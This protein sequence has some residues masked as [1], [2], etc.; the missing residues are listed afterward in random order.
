MGDFDK[1][2]ELF[3][4]EDLRAYYEF[5][6]SDPMLEDDSVDLA[7]NAETSQEVVQ[8]MTGLQLFTFMLF[9]LAREQNE[10]FERYLMS[11]S[12]PNINPYTQFWIYS[13]IVKQEA[14]N[15]Q[16]VR[17]LQMSTTSGDP[18]G[19]GEVIFN[20]PIY[21]EV[22]VQVLNEIRI[23]ITSETALPIPFAEGPVTVQLHF[24]RDQ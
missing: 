5:F 9:Q 14:V 22:D 16:M 15:N 3:P 8:H 4:L 19:Q 6:H 11:K 20:F 17:L 13:N 21:K 24:I 7:Q 23:L 1:M 2:M 18:G 10:L 12:I